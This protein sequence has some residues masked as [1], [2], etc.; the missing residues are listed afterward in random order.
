MTESTEDNDKKFVDDLIKTIRI[1]TPKIK[2][3]SRIGE[4]AENKKRPIK[5]ILSTEKDK[6]TLLRNLSSLKGNKEY[7]GISL[8]EDLTMTE[9]TVLKEWSEKAKELNLN[10]TD[11]VYRVRGD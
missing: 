9:R 8:T 11:W 6:M 2:T 7:I 3:M 5:V 1:S 10:D 4:K